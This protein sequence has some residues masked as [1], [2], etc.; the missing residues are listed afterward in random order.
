MNLEKVKKK[1]NIIYL[2]YY[3]NTPSGGNKIIY[4]HSELIN[5]I[6]LNFNSEIIH[7]KYNNKKWKNLLY[8]LSKNNNHDDIS[9]SNPNRQAELSLIVDELTLTD[10][11]IEQPCAIARS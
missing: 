5:K 3:N 4:N 11:L 9:Q 10:N 2:S 1:I 6:N 7:F 8:K